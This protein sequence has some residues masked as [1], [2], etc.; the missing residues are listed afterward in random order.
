MKALVVY[1]SRT[2]TTKKIAEIIKTKL[3]CDIEEIITETKMAGLFGYM[4]CGFEAFFKKIPRIKPA[5]ADP[6]DYDIIIIG[7]PVWAGN[8]SS[9]VRTYL[10][11]NKERFKNVAFFCTYQSS[12]VSNVFKD[13]ASLC[14]KESIVLLDVRAKE[15][16]EDDHTGKIEKFV[17]EIIENFE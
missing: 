5:K 16:T 7:T 2:G 4:K 1:Y 13:M 14:G 6:S 10:T 17:Y 12:G 9:P 15:I 8:M 3:Q 11:Q